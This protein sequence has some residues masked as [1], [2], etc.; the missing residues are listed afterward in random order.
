M[1]FFFFFIAYFKDKKDM[2]N[3]NAFSLL[4]S[5]VHK[6]SIKN[7]YFQTLNSVDEKNKF[8]KT[9][10]TVRYKNIENLT[11]NILYFFKTFVPTKCNTIS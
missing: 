2:N 10:N 1:Y 8:L 5:I 9:I 4:F 11:T 6:K 3:S 7:T